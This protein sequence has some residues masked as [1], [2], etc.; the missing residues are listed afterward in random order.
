VADLRTTS[1]TVAAL[2]RPDGFP[3]AAVYGRIDRRL[4][5]LKVLL[6]A[7]NND[8]S[9]GIYKGLYD[10]TVWAFR[11]C[12]VV[13][14]FL[15]FSAEKAWHCF[16]GHQALTHID[17]QWMFYT[18]GFKK[19]VDFDGLLPVSTMVYP[20]TTVADVSNRLVWDHNHID[21]TWRPDGRGRVWAF[22]RFSFELVWQ[23]QPAQPRGTTL[24]GPELY[25]DVVYTDGGDFHIVALRASDGAVLWRTFIDGQA[26]SSLHVTASRIYIS[27]FSFLNVLD[28]QTGR[29]VART[30]QPGASYIDWGLFA[31]PATSSGK[32]IFITIH[33][34][35]WSFWEP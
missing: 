35:A 20:G 11:G 8:E 3:H 5:W 32:Q 15:V 25:G 1:P 18:T 33:N 9:F 13:R 17:A 30:I 27:E 14:L 7:K 10:G 24:T 34:G 23:Y 16:R 4:A 12:M 26:S 22:D 31:W 28:R 19:G 2:N 29:Y 6:S 21:I